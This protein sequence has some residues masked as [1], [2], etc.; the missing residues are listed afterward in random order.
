[1]PEYLKKIYTPDEFILEYKQPNQLEY[2]NLSNY[3]LIVISDFSSEYKL[4][5]SALNSFIKDYG[6]LL[7]IPENSQ[8]KAMSEFMTSLQIPVQVT[9]DT[10]RSSSIK[11]IL[12]IRFLKVFLSKKSKILL[13]RLSGNTIVSTGMAVV[14]QIE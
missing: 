11:S 12:I 4:S 13:I 8:E 7:I 1:M 10:A 14:I 5:A 2:N 6:N 3:H 9:R